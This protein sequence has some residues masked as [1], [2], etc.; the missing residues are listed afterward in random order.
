MKWMTGVMV[1]MGTAA[2]ADIE[3]TFRDGAP[4]DRIEI[5]NIGGCEVGPMT[6]AVDLVPSPS[7]LIFDVSSQGAG[8]QVNQ[9]VEIVDGAA[10]VATMS[11]VN[12]GDQLLTLRLAEMQAGDVI[13]L[14]LD[15]DDTVSTRE[16]TVDGAEIAGAQVIV[17]REGES[18]FRTGLFD[19][20]GRALVP[21]DGCLS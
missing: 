21:L 1:L 16:I 18:L 11:V 5:A 20:S 10:L 12:D 17:T 3:V 2:T 6:L 14:T 4:K 9:P 19:A 13:R 8:V 7:G 15:L